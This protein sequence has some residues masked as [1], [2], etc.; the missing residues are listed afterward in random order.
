MSTETWRLLD[1]GKS[2]PYTNMAIDEAIL[3][4]HQKGKMLPTLRFY[5]WT[6]PTISLG[7]FQ[8]VHKEID[9]EA[10]QERG[11][12]LVRRITGGRAV[13]HD[14]EVTYSIVAREDH[15]LMTGG[16]RSSYLRLSTALVEGLKELGVPAE[17][18]SGRKGNLNRHTTTACFDAPSWYE[19]TCNSRKLVGSAQTRKGGVVLQHGSIIIS[20]NVEDFFSVLKMP[21]EKL[22]EYLKSKFYKQA[23]GLEEILGVKVEARQVKLKIKE[24][25][26]KVYGIE[27]VPGELSEEEIT[28]LKELKNKYASKNWLNGKRNNL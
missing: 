23:C 2:D 27:F 8:D 18:V 24:A 28:F 19:I 6:P 14:N 3:L 12:G 16:V 9:V 17:I 22:R 5:G 25:F 13:F 20:L 15:P 26:T 4:K 10:V 11:F 7:Y 21:S 1:T